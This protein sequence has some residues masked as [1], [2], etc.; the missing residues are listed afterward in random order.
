VEQGRAGGDAYEPSLRAST[1]RE[2]L[3]HGDTYGLLLALILL[4]YVLMGLVDNTTWS[5]PMMAVVMGAILVLAL[6]TSH[7]HRRLVIGAVVVSVACFLVALAQAAFDSDLG[8]AGLGYLMFAFTAVAPVFVLVRIFRHPE[9]TM[10]TL[11]GAFSAYLLIGLVFSGL[12]R[13]Y[14]AWS[15]GGFFAQTSDPSP[16]QYMYFSFTT[17]TTTGYGDLT[18]AQ[19]GGR[20]LTNLE[21]LVGQVFLVTIVS[22][23][24]TNLGRARRARAE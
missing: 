19:D 3:Q 8:A 12:Y 23:I 24:V 21:Q 5:R 18:P 15:A 16:V 10:E 4:G 13:G 2:R 20:V 1:F 11:L 17:L 22:G 9:I 6:H 14:D 7:A